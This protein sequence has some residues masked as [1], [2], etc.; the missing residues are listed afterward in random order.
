MQFFLGTFLSDLSQHPGHVN[1]M[2]THRWPTMILSPILLIVGMFFASYPGDHPEYMPWSQ[3]LLDLSL[4]IFPEKPD[5]PRSYTGLG[6]VFIAVGIHF[7]NPIK[8]ALSNKYFLWLGKNSFAVY[9][10]HGTLIRTVL[11]WCYYG[12]VVPPNV[13]N[14]K[15]ESV[16]GPAL[17]LDSRWRFWFWLP[18][19][20][21]LLYFT[22]YLWTKYVDPF[23][24]HVTQR[25]ENYCFE[26]TTPEISNKERQSPLPR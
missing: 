10:I 2:A 24:A 12:I 14:E 8:N 25:L 17:H 7:S 1:W 19:W 4:Y 21:A 5:I 23:C 13:T 3:W 9:L 26:D 15:G 6:M 20:F 11:A 16:N 22:A 18:L